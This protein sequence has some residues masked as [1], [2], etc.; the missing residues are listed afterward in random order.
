MSFFQGIT[1]ALL[2]VSISVMGLIWFVTLRA[3]QGDADGQAPNRNRSFVRIDA[4][5]LVLDKQ[6]G[7]WH[8]KGSP[9]NGQAL[10][11][12]HNGQEASR[13]PFIE[14]KR[15]G[16]AF[17]WYEDGA[18]ASKKTYKANRLEGTSLTWWPNGYLSSE[19]NYVD[20]VRHGVQKRWYPNGQLARLMHFNQGKEEGL[21]QAWLETGKLYVNYEARNGRF[22]GMKRA[23]LCYELE[24]EVVQK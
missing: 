9:F 21:Q 16:T 23:N 6:L 15:Q 14:G 5:T 8:Y 10:S 11:W 19:S 3:P 1:K 7:V 4:S 24:D 12:H 20:R 22:F 2:A 17:S 18:L 13:I